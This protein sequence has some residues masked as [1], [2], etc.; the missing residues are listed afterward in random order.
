MLRVACVW[1]MLSRT[2]ARGCAWP[3]P[4]T[5]IQPLPFHSSCI[6]DSLPPP[7][8]QGLGVSGLHASARAITESMNAQQS[9]PQI[10]GGWP[11]KPRCALNAET[12]G[13]D[14]TAGNHAADQRTVHPLP[15]CANAECGRN[16]PRRRWTIRFPWL[17]P[18]VTRDQ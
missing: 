9:V 11:P 6:F 2:C 14:S 8:A 7:S 4:L 17:V 10:A 12:R 16:G 13:V 3:H 15:P 5:R 18:C 1:H